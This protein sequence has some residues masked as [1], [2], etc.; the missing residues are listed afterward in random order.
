MNHAMGKMRRVQTRAWCLL[1]LAAGLSVAGAARTA[2]AAEGAG[3]APAQV[4]SYRKAK[5]P[6]AVVMTDLHLKAQGRAEPLEVRVRVPV[7]QQADPLPVVIFSHGAGGSSD[8]FPD[9]CEHWASQ[10]YVVINPTHSDSVKLR[11]AKGETL[12]P[13]RALAQQIVGGVKLKDRK[14]D[15]VLILDSF[16]Q[17]IEQAQQAHPQTQGL[18]LDA[19]RVALAGH[20]AG[21]LTSQMLAGARFFG[22][23]GLRGYSEPEPRIRSFILISGQGTGNRYFNKES[24]KDIASPMLVIA[25]SEDYS[26]VTDEKPIQRCDPY[27]YAPAG[28]KFLVYIEGATHGSYAGKQVVRFLK[29]KPPENLDY[30]TDVTAFSTLAF[31]DMTL[32]G[33][34]EARAY[35]THHELLKYPGGRL[36]TAHK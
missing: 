21:A 24:W 32:R 2:T 3:P 7:S 33:S 22:P 34:A 19:G 10:G 6:Y 30:I 8:A 27:H 28:D 26:P 29:E 5:G 36:D 35:L 25:G 13:N 23:L 11:K 9:L 16:P 12:D 15:V 4:G 31:L 1:L 14:A 17:I 18:K 20:S